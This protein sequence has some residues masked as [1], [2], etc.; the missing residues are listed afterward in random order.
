MVRIDIEGHTQ[1]AFTYFRQKPSS[2]KAGTP[3]SCSR[4][5]WEQFAA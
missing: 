3:T 1:V 2:D 5:L 4:E